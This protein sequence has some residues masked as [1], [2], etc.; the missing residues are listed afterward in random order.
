[1]KHIVWAVIAAAFIFTATESYARGFSVGVFGAY[2]IDG[3]NIEDSIIEKR[4]KDY[5]YNNPNITKL[6]YDTVII[7]GAGAF[8]VYN[9]S[10]GFFIR[11]GAEFYQLFSGGEISKSI[12]DNNT[13][14]MV[15]YDYKIDYTAFALPVLFGLNISPDKGRTNLYFGAGV[16]TAM[17][18][19]YR[20]TKVID[21]S[22][23]PNWYYRYE[24]E[25]D[26]IITGFA[27]II[28]IE[29]KIFSNVGVLIEYAFYRCEENRKESLDIY[30]F[31]GGNE[32]PWGS[33][34]YTETYG[35]PRQQAR[36]GVKYSF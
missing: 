30:F 22:N 24:S 23:Y 19:I 1:M 32:N 10:N 2:S 27:G 17:N 12:Y 9:F 36:I 16:V 15:N 14:S 11:A 26:S 35:L 18:K 8:A 33:N 3:G 25:N 4:T 34:S 31:S 28:G 7:P 13:G 6:E 21:T 5:Q 20:E 29:K